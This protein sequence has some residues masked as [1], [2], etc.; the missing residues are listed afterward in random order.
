MNQNSGFA[1]GVIGWGFV[2]Q[3]TG[4]GFGSNPKNKIF[5][6]DKF[7]ESQNTLEEVIAKSEYIF[8]C[9]PTPI[10][11]D[12]SGMDMSIVEGVIDEVAPKIKGSDKVLIIKSTSLPGTT[13][14]MMKKYP[15]VNFVMNP[16]FL[17]QKNANRD[18]LNPARTVLGVSNQDLGFRMQKLYETILPES[19]QYIITDPTS[20]ELIKYMS[21]LILASKVLLANEF[22]EISKA[23]GAN[24]LDIQKA[25]ESDPRIGTHLGVRAQMETLDLGEPV[26]PKT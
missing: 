20:A 7:K 19:Q 24:Y 26:S 5:W 6:Y 14:K 18:F 21:N 13:K 8:I 4:F 16:E 1:V 12:Y 25:V 2:G 23:V 10:F 9:V 15:G 3:A 17:T 11:D 22:Y